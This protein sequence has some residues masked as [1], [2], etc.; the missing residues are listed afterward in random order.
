MPRYTTGIG[1]NGGIALT[2]ADGTIVD[3]VGVLTVG[4]AYREG[5]A[6]LTQLTTNTNRSYERKP[7]GASVTL[8]DT[9]D[10]AVDFV[11]LNGTPPNLPNPQNIVLTAAPA[12]VDFG[13][14]ILPATSVQ[15]VAIKNVLLADVTLTS[16]FAISGADATDFAVGAPGTTALAGGAETTAPVTFAPASLGAKSA[17]LTVTSTNGGTQTVALSGLAVC[18][19]ITVTGSLPAAEFGFPYSQTFSASGGSGPYAFRVSAGTPP[20]GLGLDQSGVLSGTPSALGT[21][22]FTVEART[23]IGCTG[24]ADFALTIVDTAPPALTLPADITATATSPG[25]AVVSFNATALD[26]ADGARPV[27]CTPASGS[28]FAIGSTSVACTA[29]DTRGNAASGSIRVTVTEPTQAGRMLGDG[30]IENGAVRHDFDFLVQ[31]R[32]TAADAGALR[33]RVKTDRAGRDQED[34][35]EAL[36]TRAVFL[37]SAASRPDRR[38]LA[39]DTVLFSGAGRWNGA[40]GYTFEARATDAGER[41]TRARQIRDYD[42]RRGRPDRGVGRRRA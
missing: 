3:Q 5:N 25:G 14:V 2:T 9:G 4:T 15:T 28:T 34:R 22:T 31:E 24:T 30:R 7:G 18:P 21:F 33:Y 40:G 17:L 16:P 27:T 35:F 26:L 32:A 11:L 20:A 36:A 6:L 39:I 12:A 10:N 8:Q 13:S 1:D 42:S 19:A 23:A 38:Q 37:T 29:S 41:G